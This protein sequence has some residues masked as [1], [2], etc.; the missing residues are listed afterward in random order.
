MPDFLDRLGDELLN[1]AR[2][3]RTDALAPAVPA[4]APRAPRRLREARRA[5]PRWLLVALALLIVDA[6]PAAIATRGRQ[7]PGPVP[8]RPGGALALTPDPA[9]TAA[10][11]ILRRPQTATDQVPLELPI[12][13]SGASGANLGLARHASGAGGAEAWV[14][15]G[16]G[17]MCL[18]SAWPANRGG[19]ASCQPNTA[20]IAGR[21]E[22]SSGSRRAPGTDFIAG[23]VPDGV[24]S[25][26]VNLPGGRT[27]TARV[28]ENVYLIAV[29]GTPE[30]VTF[31]GTHGVVKLEGV[32]LPRG[33]TG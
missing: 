13:L 24:S 11:A 3:P 5:R 14:V 17:S 9:D 22:V 20:A 12:G 8:P 18:I 10:F 33:A 2:A 31:T 19:G 16:R 4:L 6:G 29:S 1:A 15:P 7:G 21:L 25:I 28:R 32:A 23:L 26:T 27:D 30:S